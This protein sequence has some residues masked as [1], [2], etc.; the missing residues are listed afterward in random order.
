MPTTLEVTTYTFKELDED[1]QEKLISKF[2]ENQYDWG[3]V[4]EREYTE[5]LQA[6]CNMFGTNWE[7]RNYDYSVDIDTDNLPI[8]L[9]I[10]GLRL[11][12]W[13]INKLLRH[14]YAKRK[15]YQ[16]GQGTQRRTRTTNFYDIADCPFTGFIADW[17]LLEPIHKFIRDPRQFPNWQKMD[18]QDI[19]WLCEKKFNDAINADWEHQCSREYAIEHLTESDNVYLSDGRMF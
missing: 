17:N 12:T 13:L 10:T 7:S 18:L 3:L 4:W 8:S 5:S 1:V 16:F 9:D 19:V 11:R 15:I 2:R 14:L 6:F